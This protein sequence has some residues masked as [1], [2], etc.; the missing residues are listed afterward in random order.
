MPTFEIKYAPYAFQL[1]NGCF[2]VYKPQIWGFDR[3]R[4]VILN[5][6]AT[7]KSDCK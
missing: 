1:L 4:K 5:K 3:L 7:G 2:C 6:L